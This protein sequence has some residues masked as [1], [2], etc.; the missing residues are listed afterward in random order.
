MNK[1]KLKLELQEKIAGFNNDSLIFH[2]KF[3][4]ELQKILIKNAS[5]GEGEVLKKL[6]VIFEQIKRVK[7]SIILQGKH[8]L[9]KNYVRDIDCY[10][11]HLKTKLVNIR[12]LLA[13]N[14]NEIP[15]FLVAFNEKEKNDYAK[16]K[17]TFEERYNDFKGGLK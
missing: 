12:L 10:S 13:F 16:Q 17:R 1:E 4:E 5:G 7:K 11:L 2:D 8:E 14:S 9:L 3:I 15:L 6:V